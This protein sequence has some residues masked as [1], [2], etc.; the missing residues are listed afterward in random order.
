M[1]DEYKYIRQQLSVQ[2]KLENKINLHFVFKLM[3]S[4]YKVLSFL[5]SL[6]GTDYKAKNNTGGIERTIERTTASLEGNSWIE[7]N[8]EGLPLTLQGSFIAFV[9]HIKLIKIS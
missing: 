6:F 2:Q 1:C 9:T 3:V 5:L 8:L 4:N 7:P